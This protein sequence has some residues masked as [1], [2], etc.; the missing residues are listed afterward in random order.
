MPGSTSSPSSPSPG[1]AVWF[2]SHVGRSQ[3]DVSRRHIIPLPLSQD[4]Y[5]KLRLHHPPRRRR[6]SPGSVETMGDQH[7]FMT[8]RSRR[9]ADDGSST[10]GDSTYGSSPPSATHDTSRVNFHLKDLSVFAKTLEDVSGGPPRCGGEEG[11]GGGGI[12]WEREGLRG[13]EAGGG[14]GERRRGAIDQNRRTDIGED[15]W[16]RNSG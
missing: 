13:N 8:I 7:P 9:P 3:I 12:S 10:S 16:D 14:R 5:I 15:N 2:A 4:V 11:G 1:V 6:W